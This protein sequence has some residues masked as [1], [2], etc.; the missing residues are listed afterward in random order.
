MS[1]IIQEF[2]PIYETNQRTTGDTSCAGAS[3]TITNP[4][5]FTSTD[6]VGD[7]I[8]CA[9][10]TLQDPQGDPQCAGSLTTVFTAPPSSTTTSATALPSTGL[11]EV[12]VFSDAYCNDFILGYREIDLLEGCGAIDP[13]ALSYRFNAASA[14]CRSNDPAACHTEVYIYGEDSC[15]SDMVPVG[16][17]CGYDFDCQPASWRGGVSIIGVANVCPNAALA[18]PDVQS[19]DNVTSRLEFALHPRQGGTGD[20]DDDDPIPGRPLCGSSPPTSK[21]SLKSLGRIAGIPE[22]VSNATEERDHRTPGGNSHLAKRTLRGNLEQCDVPGYVEGRQ[23][24]AG[25]NTL[26]AESATSC[27]LFLDQFLSSDPTIRRIMLMYL[28]FSVTKQQSF[29]DQPFTIG[30]GNIKGEI[31]WLTGCTV[32]TVVSS[33]TV[34]MVSDSTTSVLSVLYRS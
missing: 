5:P 24:E 13:P 26:I 34:Y 7:I 30:T 19:L 20:D 6:A 11:L 10:S 25:I 16:L 15:P 28:D 14:N 4:F 8:R 22:G 12:D 18:A 33:T 23:V 32:I 31:A 17:G 29:G 21:R 27:M 3:T 9:S 1:G 2:N